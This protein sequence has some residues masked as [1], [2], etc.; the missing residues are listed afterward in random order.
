MIPAA[1]DYVR[2]RSLDDALAPLGIDHFE[3]M[4][5][6]PERVWTAIQRAKAR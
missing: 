4:P 6:T 3:T 1:F 5:L 2:A